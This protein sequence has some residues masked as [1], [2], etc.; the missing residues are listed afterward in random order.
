MQSQAKTVAEYLRELP[1]DRRAAISKVRAVVRK[2]LPKGFAETMGYG[3]ISYVVPHKIYPPGYHCD[4]TT[5]VPF[6]SIASQKNYMAFYIMTGYDPRVETAL[7]D[8]FKN[9]G[10]K[11]DMGKSC[12]RFKKLD[13]LPLDVIGKVV[14]MVGLEEY[15]AKHEEVRLAAEA[16]RKASRKKS[17]S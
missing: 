15:L 16:R 6:A 2:N 9:A 12:I 8:G 5:P 7:K 3:M 13:D 1:E 14:G 4:P 17:R 11:L 10:K